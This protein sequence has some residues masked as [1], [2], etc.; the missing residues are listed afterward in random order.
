M[1]KKNHKDRLIQ[2]I[3]DNWVLNFLLLIVILL[4]GFHPTATQLIQQLFPT[5]FAL[6]WYVTAY[7]IFYLAYPGINLMLGNLTQRQHL[8]TAMTLIVMYFGFAWLKGD[9]FF[10]SVLLYWLAAYVL[11]SYIRHY[12]IKTFSNKKVLFIGI[13]IGF[14]GMV[15]IDSLINFLG[16]HVGAL[17]N[18]AVH[19]Q[20]HNNP[21]VLL[22][23]LSL[24]GFAIR[25]KGWNSRIINYLSSLSL[26]V[27][28]IHENQMVRVFL[29]PLYFVYIKQYFG[30]ELV[31][32]WLL[33]FA[34]GL[35]AVSVILSI[36]YKELLAPWVGS[37]CE[38]VWSKLRKL[39]KVV[40]LLEWIK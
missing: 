18:K 21:F 1:S 25:K 28:V 3:G 35:F 20:G 2:L 22:L 32:L 4:L 36:G 12:T 34:V 23:A 8:L 6:N 33:L 40:V 16:L 14:A 38:V 26:F 11:V 27:Y 39:N 7:V 10:P 30:F 37:M 17:N 15:G 13:G 19:F 9:M 31:L 24:L 29:R 5:L